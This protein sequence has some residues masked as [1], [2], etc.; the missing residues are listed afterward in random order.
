MYKTPSILKTHPFH[1]HGAITRG[2]RVRPDSWSVWVVWP[3]LACRLPTRENNGNLTDITQISRPVTAKSSS[4]IRATGRKE[5]NIKGGVCGGI[6]LFSIDCLFS[7]DPVP[8][9]VC[10]CSKYILFFFLTIPQRNNYKIMQVRA[11]IG[12][13]YI[14]Y[15]YFYI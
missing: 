7:S 14:M 10:F 6:F 9:L 5:N 13:V 12:T 15:R 8:W 3:A 4:T 1:N 2:G 11:Y